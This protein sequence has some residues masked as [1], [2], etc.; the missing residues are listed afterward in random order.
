MDHSVRSS[1][2]AWRDKLY[3]IIFEA[4]TPAGKRFDIALIISIM[5]GVAIV[6]LDSMQEMQKEYRRAL[7]IAE[8]CVTGLFTLE[9]LAR[10]ISAPRPWVYVRSL[11]GVIDLLALLPAFLS[12]FFP[13]AAYL[14]TVRALRLLRIFR[15]LK[16]GR[17]LVEIQV[18]SS[19]LRQSRQKIT[20]FLTAVAVLVII[21]GSAMYVIEGPEHGFSSI[22]KSIYWAI[23]TLTT[24]GYGDLSPATPWGQLIASIAMILGYGMIAVP[25]GIVSSEL[26]RAHAVHHTLIQPVVCGE[27]MLEGHEIDAQ[28]CRGCGASLVSETQRMIQ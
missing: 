5:I 11:Y 15:I 1:R 24:V 12:I 4:N 10:L 6:M 25:T 13:G 16:L 7:W 19:A 2:A 17:Y 3:Q 8:W 20:V 18:I 21:L 28:Y 26:I 22:P 9:Y 23:V 27:C 14:M